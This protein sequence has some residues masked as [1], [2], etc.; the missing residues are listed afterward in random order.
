MTEILFFDQQIDSKWNR[1]VRH[2]SKI[3]TPFL[4]DSSLEIKQTYNAIQVSVDELPTSQE[5]PKPYIYETIDDFDFTKLLDE[6]RSR[7]RLPE[8]LQ[9][10]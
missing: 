1:S 8:P 2:R 4:K 10:Y 3:P 9:F 6:T 5:V 7:A